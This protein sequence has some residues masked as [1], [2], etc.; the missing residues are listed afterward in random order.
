LEELEYFFYQGRKPNYRFL[1][2]IMFKK[3]KK[4]II[5]KSDKKTT[6]KTN[7]HGDT[8]G[9]SKRFSTSKCLLKQTY[10]SRKHTNVS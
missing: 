2:V 6:W 10:C 7:L 5:P 1:I 3:K 9:G 8:G 4:N